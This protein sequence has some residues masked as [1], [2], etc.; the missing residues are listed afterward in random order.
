DKGDACTRRVV[1]QGLSSD[2]T[3]H[4]VVAVSLLPERIDAETEL[5]EVVEHPSRVEASPGR[6]RPG[7]AGPAT[8]IRDRPRGRPAL[9][10]PATTRR[11]AASRGGKRR[12]RPPLA[13]PPHTARRARTAMPDS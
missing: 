9:P 7:H 3:K 13:S 6:R 8:I 4:V 1:P 11:Y 5:M 2:L 12:A 10:G